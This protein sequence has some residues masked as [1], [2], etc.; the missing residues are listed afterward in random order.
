MRRL[1]GELQAQQAEGAQLDIAII[2][3]F[4]ALGLISPEERR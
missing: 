1:V 4:T 3:N 2:K